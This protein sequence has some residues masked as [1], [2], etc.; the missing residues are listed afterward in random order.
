MEKD[1]DCFHFYSRWRSFS[2][3]PYSLFYQKKQKKT[4]IHLHTSIL[5]SHFLFASSKRSN[6]QMVMR[7]IVL[8][9]SSVNNKV[10]RSG[11]TDNFVNSNYRYLRYTFSSNHNVHKTLCRSCFW[12]PDPL[13]DRFY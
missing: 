6:L 5:N 12:A 1:P 8:Q 4:Y 9:N 11:R 10:N 2:I 13:I 3:H 7:Y